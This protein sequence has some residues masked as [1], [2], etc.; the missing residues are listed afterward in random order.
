MAVNDKRIINCTFDD[1]ISDLVN[2][3]NEKEEIRLR[4]SIISELS[5][6][7]AVST[8][9]DEIYSECIDEAVECINL[10]REILWEREKRIELITDKAVE[11]VV[12]KIFTE[13][14]K[15]AEDKKRVSKKLFVEKGEEQE[16]ASK[17]VAIKVQYGG[18]EIQKLEHIQVTQAKGQ[19]QQSQNVAIEV[20]CGGGESDDVVMAVHEGEPRL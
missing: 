12:L 15:Y 10:E 8:I 5:V 4:E 13:E 2:E 17:N 16:G 7:R 9:F 11:I 19:G 14:F 1:L 6:E 20:K 18:M 3:E